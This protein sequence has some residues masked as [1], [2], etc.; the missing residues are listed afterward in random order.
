M[1]VLL[2]IKLRK[3]KYVFFFNINIIPM[4]MQFASK[5]SISVKKLISWFQFSFDPSKTE[6]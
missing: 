6:S 4:L 5:S 3:Q 2:K 1:T